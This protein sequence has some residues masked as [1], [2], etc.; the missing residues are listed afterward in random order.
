MVK[1]SKAS[2]KPKAAGKAKR[3]GIR[4]HALKKHGELTKS[5]RDI[6][7][8]GNAGA[9]TSL[10][11]ATRRRHR[12]R[13]GNTDGDR[14]LPAGTVT[15]ATRPMAPAA[16]AQARAFGAARSEPVPTVEEPSMKQMFHA[17]LHAF[18]RLAAR[19]RLTTAERAKLLAVSERT[20]Q[21]WAQA[22]PALDINALDRLQLILRT[23]QHL[24]E[25][26]PVTDA[27][28]ARVFRREGSAEDSDYP[29]RSL[30]DALAVP[31]ILEMHANARRFA[32]LV[33]AV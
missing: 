11:A 28:Q 2:A 22:P 15:A 5:A 33:H 30:L 1:K 32:A 31:S 13:S 8:L 14:R 25:L 18:W 16:S 27:E 4:K 19:F 26:A 7:P 9:G 20:C 17:S 23:Y 24:C 3:A 12:I 6:G 10:S 29:Q 21:R